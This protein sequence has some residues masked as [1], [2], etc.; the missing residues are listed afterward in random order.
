MLKI[1]LK[2]EGMMCGMCEAHSNKAIQDAFKVKKVS[3]SHKD[4]ETIILTENDISDADLLSV[5]AKAG[6]E[7]TGITRENYEKKGLFS[8]LKK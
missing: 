5:I 1:T 7:V 3:S 2:V 8:S 4:N 6:Y